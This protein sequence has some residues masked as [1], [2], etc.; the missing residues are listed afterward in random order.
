MSLRVR[1]SDF[2]FE[3][4]PSLIAQSPTA[5]REH[6]RL[7]CFHRNT[8]KMEHRIFH[9]L[10]D[11]LPERC[12]LVLND[13][14][15]LSARLRAVDRVTNRAFE[16]MLL[17]ANQTNDWWA[18]VRPGKHAPLGR[19]LQLR[20][21][22]GDLTAITATVTEINLEGH[23]RFRFEGTADILQELSGMGEMPLPPYIKRP[24]GNDS[25]LDGERYQTTYAAHLGSVA[26]PT[27]GL[28]FTPE[29]LGRIEASGRQTAKVT[30]H[31]GLGTFAPVKEEHL[32]NHPM[33]LEHF[34]LTDSTAQLLNQATAEGRPIVAVGT[35]ST[36]VLESASRDHEGRFRAL[37]GSTRIFIRPPYSFSS[38]QGL[39]TNFHLPQ[40]TLVM[41]VSAFLAPGETRGREKMLQ[42]YA[43]AIREQYRFFSYGDAMMIL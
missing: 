33:H 42:V 11:L 36:R 23:R 6:S 18:L 37:R 29:L 17:E 30:L 38:I 28:H 20:S 13:S 39:I 10:P 43:E 26:A 9:E 2:D 5:S 8:G 12:L 7:L 34:E 15:V 41:L 14:K 4:P 40:S 35:T 22:K 3:L 27:A 24:V 32:E 21:L 25:A 16:V 1:T 19:T 31:V